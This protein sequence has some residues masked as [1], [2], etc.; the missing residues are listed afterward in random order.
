MFSCSEEVD[1]QELSGRGYGRCKSFWGGLVAAH[2]VNFPVHWRQLTEYLQVRYSE[3]CV[4]GS[5]ETCPFLI[6][7]P[8]GGGWDGGQAHGFLQCMLLH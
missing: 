2:G 4:R 5:L 7:L 6:H 3:P 1:V 8:A